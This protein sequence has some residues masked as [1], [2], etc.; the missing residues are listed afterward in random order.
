V[1]GH[2]QGNC[3]RER[4]GKAIKCAKAE[5]TKDAGG[6]WKMTEVPGSEFELKPI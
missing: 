1:V 6:A 3:R 4:P 2:D 5:W